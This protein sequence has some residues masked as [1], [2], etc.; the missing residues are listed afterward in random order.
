MKNTKIINRLID[1]YLE[2]SILT[3]EEH[4]TVRSLKEEMQ[5]I[6]YKD[7]CE[8]FILTAKT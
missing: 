8:E 7:C 3:Q 4:K 5:A 1:Y 6:N 2:G